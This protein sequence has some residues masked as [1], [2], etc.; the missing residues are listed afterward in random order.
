M[1]VECVLP[2]LDSMSICPNYQITI[3]YL[4]CENQLRTHGKCAVHPS[5]RTSLLPMGPVPSFI[6]PMTGFPLIDPTEPLF[7]HVALK[8]SVFSRQSPFQYSVLGPRRLHTHF[9]WEWW[10]LLCQ[11]EHRILFGLFAGR[12]SPYPLQDNQTIWIYKC[13]EQRVYRHKRCN[14]NP[15]WSISR[16]SYTLNTKINPGSKIYDSDARSS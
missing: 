10:Y 12:D 5:T 9:E 8:V 2:P 14:R 6:D 15:S 3:P 7:C 1:Y 16:Y 13:V 11:W 4:V